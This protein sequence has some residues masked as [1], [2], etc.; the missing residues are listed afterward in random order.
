MNEKISA[1]KVRILVNLDRTAIQSLDGLATASRRSRS[2]VLSLLI[3]LA[4]RNMQIKAVLGG[5]R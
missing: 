4:N 2:G 3:E 1:R 5:A